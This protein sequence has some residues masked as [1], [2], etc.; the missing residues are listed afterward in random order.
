MFVAGGLWDIIAIDLALHAPWTGNCSNMSMINT[1]HTKVRQKLQS[2]CEVSNWLIMGA[3]DS[4]MKLKGK[5][6]NFMFMC[7]FV[8]YSKAEWL[9]VIFEL[10]LL[11]E[12]SPRLGSSNVNTGH[13]NKRITFIG[14]LHKSGSLCPPI[15][16]TC[17]HETQKLKITKNTRLFAI[18][19]YLMS[20][21][22]QNSR[23]PNYKA[24]SL[25]Y[26]S[27]NRKP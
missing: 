7:Q 4:R 24:T 20:F 3:C 16:V 23:S 17:Q 21:E 12:F 25:L 19:F 15:R 2:G 5:S 18:V 13:K 9:G 27:I 26:I 11:W 14:I 6:S 8:R 10:L 1:I 22:L